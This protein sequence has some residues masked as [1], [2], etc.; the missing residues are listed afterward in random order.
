[1][2]YGEKCQTTELA[3]LRGEIDAILTRSC[4]TPIIMSTP[5]TKSAR[6]SAAIFE[7]AP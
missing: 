4:G 2:C 3:E 1:M 6:E 5:P 7:A